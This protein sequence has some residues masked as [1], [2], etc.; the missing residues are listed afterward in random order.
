MVSDT[1]TK[2]LSAP[3]LTFHRSVMMGHS[4]F[5]VRFLRCI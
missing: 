2:R 5:Y 3:D 1:L 4:V